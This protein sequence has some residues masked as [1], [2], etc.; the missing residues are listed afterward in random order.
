MSVHVS[1]YNTPVGE[2]AMIVKI[3]LLSQ[4]RTGDNG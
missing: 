1:R 2:F 4:C 3:K